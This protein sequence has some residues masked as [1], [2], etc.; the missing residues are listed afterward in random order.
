MEE[1]QTKSLL[2][3][4][5]YFTPYSV[6]VFSFTNPVDLETYMRRFRSLS[7]PIKKIAFDPAVADYIQEKLVPNF[8]LNV[9]QGKELTRVI[10]DILLADVF[11]R[12]V[13][14]EIQNRLRVDPN[15]S[16][17]IAS[18]VIDELFAPAMGEIKEIHRQKF[19]DRQSQSQPQTRPQQQS[20]QPP[21]TFSNPAASLDINENN[22]LDLRNKDQ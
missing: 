11:V 14:A 19:G 12:D 2:D 21:R 13:V 10:R 4:F 6:D 8:G 1:D 3:D 18:M 7:E 9:E 15:I 5:T 20:Q 22:V 16:N 17:Q